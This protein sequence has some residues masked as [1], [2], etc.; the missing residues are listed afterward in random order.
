MRP[1]TVWLS[2]VGLPA[3]ACVMGLLVG[4]DIGRVVTPVTATVEHDGDAAVTAAL[5]GSAEFTPTLDN[6]ASS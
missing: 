2:G 3:A 1:R 5:D 6:E 4:A